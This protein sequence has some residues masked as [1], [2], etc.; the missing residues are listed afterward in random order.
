[1]GQGLNLSCVVN[2]FEVFIWK[3]GVFGSVSN[4]V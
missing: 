3:C 4:D 2:G 1:M